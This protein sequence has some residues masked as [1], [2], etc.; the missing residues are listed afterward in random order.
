MDRVFLL[1]AHFCAGGWSPMD[2]FDSPL[3]DLPVT[4]QSHMMEDGTPGG[5][6]PDSDSSGGFHADC[7]SSLARQHTL[8]YLVLRKIP[9][10]R[11]RNP[12]QT[13]NPNHHENLNYGL[14]RTQQFVWNL[15]GESP[16]K[17]ETST[18]TRSF[19]VP[20]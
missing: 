19:G 16:Q 10:V 9:R 3:T 5:S 2:G 8:L 14:F 7:P 20:C 11:S 15:N 18:R 1:H 12:C 13:T 4:T 6:G 17:A